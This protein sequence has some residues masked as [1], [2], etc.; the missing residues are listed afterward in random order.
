VTNLSWAKYTTLKEPEEIEEISPVRCL[1]GAAG[2]LAVGVL[3]Y[4]LIFIGLSL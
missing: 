3:G 4:V 1:C 2:I